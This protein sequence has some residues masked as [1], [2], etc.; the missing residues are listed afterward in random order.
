MPDKPDSNL[1][2][3]ELISKLRFLSSSSS[4]FSALPRVPGARKVHVW[5]VISQGIPRNQ[6]QAII[7]IVA[8][9]IIIIV[10]IHQP[11]ARMVHVW[12]V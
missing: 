6:M 8:F 11:G 7:I 2:L 1:K 5:V 3:E 10:I 4:P 12:V 9:V